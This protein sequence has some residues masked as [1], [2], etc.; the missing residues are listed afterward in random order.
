MSTA[1]RV[2]GT[3]VHVIAVVYM[4]Q[5]NNDRALAFIIIGLLWFVLANQEDLRTTLTK[6][7]LTKKGNDHE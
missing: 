1:P 5:G 7:A 6:Y 4:F 3:L 2:L